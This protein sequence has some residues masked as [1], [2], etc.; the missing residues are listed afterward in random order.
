MTIDEH[1]HSCK[2]KGLVSG[3][4][5]SELALYPS[6]PAVQAA[7]G[8]CGKEWMVTP[9]RKGRSDWLARWVMV[10]SIAALCSIWQNDF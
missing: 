5:A 8:L 1:S 2:V 10:T 7:S 6:P 3:I 4:R 9:H